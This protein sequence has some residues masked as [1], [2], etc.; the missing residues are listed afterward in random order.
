[1][2]RRLGLLLAVLAMVTAGCAGDDDGGGG[3][4][5]A[6]EPVKGGTLRIV[7]EED[8]DFWDTGSAYTV[9]AWAFARLHVRTLYSFDSS[10][11][12][13]EANEPVPDIA[14]GP[15]T[16]SDD[17]LTYTFKLRPNV[18]YAPPVNR[19]V[20]AEDFIYAVER[21]FDKKYPSPN[22]YNSVFKGAEE[23]A[24]RMVGV[25]VAAVTGADLP[26]RLA[27]I[28]VPGCGIVL[29]N[30]GRTF[31]SV[32]DIPTFVTVHPSSLLRAPDPEARKQA[33]DAFVLDLRDAVARVD[34]A[35]GVGD[36]HSHRG[37]AVAFAR[38]TGTARLPWPRRGSTVGS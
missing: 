8:V 14:A 21:Q 31:T 30:R 17:R 28:V 16:V 23:F 18:R 19:A 2:L 3:G 22:P 10:K 13:E 34:D 15:P 38:W 7:N 1:M 6:G 24:E 9:T 11:S 33:F 36:H 25:L 5:S 37:A 32:F 35:V 12:A 29:Q 26:H 20:K 27:A 4:E